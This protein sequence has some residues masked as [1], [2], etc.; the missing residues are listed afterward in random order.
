MITVSLVDLLPVD[1]RE[2][3]CAWARQEQRDELDVMSDALRDYG[4]ILLRGA[5]G[6]HNNGTAPEPEKVL[7][8]PLMVDLVKST[9]AVPVGLEPPR[10]AK[11]AILSVI[12]ETPISLAEIQSA[13]LRDLHWPVPM[14]TVRGTVCVLSKEGLIDRVG[15]G[16]YR[17]AA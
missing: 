11:D 2:M 17:V 1:V 16:Q 8:V 13:V 3:V 7:T 6:F 9:L 10:N 5:V 4:R 15:T 12:H 14:T